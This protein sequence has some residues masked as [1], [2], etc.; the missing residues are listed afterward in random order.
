MGGDSQKGRPGGAPW[1]RRRFVGAAVAATG[2]LALGGCRRRRGVGLRPLRIGYVTPATGPLAPF[3]AADDYV[4]AGVR[5]ALAQ[6]IVRGAARHPVEILAEDSQSNP[7][8]AA[9]V[10]SRLIDA[11]VDLVLAASTADTVN[12]V[13]DLC[14]AGEVPCLTTDTPWQAYFFGRSGDPR[15]GFEWTYHFCWGVDQLFQVYLD[16]WDRLDTNKVVAALWPNDAEGNAFSEPQHGFASAMRARGYTPV[17]TGRFQPATDDFSAQIR[18]FKEAGAQLLTGVLTPPAFQTFWTQAAQQDFRPRIATVA[19]ALLFPAV[20][21]SMGARGHGLTTEVWWSPYH[22]FRSSLGG[23]SATQYAS[24][25]EQSSGRNWTQ[26]MGFRHALFEVAASVLA[27]AGSIDDPRSIRAAI[28]STSM[29]TLVGRVDFAR[30]PVPNIATT[31]LVG[32]QWQAQAGGGIVLQVV[33]DT[34]AP[35][36]PVTAPLQVLPDAR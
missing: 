33:D 15:R 23:M 29:D 13:A 9:E 34:R 5:A 30:G 14:E 3:S 32:G 1:S 12:P 16:L 10:T 35:A 18:A 36:I 22:P 27:R 7:N 2:T 20:A 25:Y 17:D 19:K 31:P 24:G 4:L 28:A 21:A 26:P 6:G 8:R 11:D